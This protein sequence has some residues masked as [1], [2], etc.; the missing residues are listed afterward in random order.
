MIRMCLVGCLLV[1][2][3]YGKAYQMIIANNALLNLQKTF[4]KSYLATTQKNRLA[5]EKEVILQI[6]KINTKKESKKKIEYLHIDTKNK[7]GM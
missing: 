5:L 2:F 3:T 6:Y 1:T 7:G 4:I